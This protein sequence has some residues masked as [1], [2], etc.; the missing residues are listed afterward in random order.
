MP[1]DRFS[2]PS[3]THLVG[4]NWLPARQTLTLTDP[5]TGEDLAIIG[6][7]GEADI[8]A[9]VA[10]AHA[11]RAGDWGRM[12]ALERGRILTRLGQLVLTRVEEL[13]ELEARDVGKPLTQAR[14]DAVALARYMEFYGGAAD[15]ITGETIPYLDGYTVYTLREP[16]GV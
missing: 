12:P 4:G 10:A 6:R 14:A 15:K 8:D 11:A 13:A 16:H 5:S 7:G 9:A 2:I 3:A 1:L